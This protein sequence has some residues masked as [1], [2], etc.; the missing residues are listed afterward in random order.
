MDRRSEDRLDTGRSAVSSKRALLEVSKTIERDVIKAV[1]DAGADAAEDAAPVVIVLFQDASYFDKAAHRFARVAEHAEVIAGFAGQ[2]RWLPD[3]V[4][5]LPLDDLDEL[6]EDWTLLVL[7]AYA[8]VG[9][10]STDAHRTVSLAALEA[11][12]AFHS[13]VSCSPPLIARQALDVLDVAGSLLPVEVAARARARAEA[14]LQT[15]SSPSERTHQAIYEATLDRM[16]QLGQQLGL[17]EDLSRIDPLTGAY[18]RRFLEEQLASLGRRHPDVGVLAFDL[19][20]FKDINDRYGHAAGDTALRAFVELLRSRLRP[21]SMIVRLGG[22]E[23]V[24]LVPGIDLDGAHAR[25][26]EIVQA[27]QALRLPSP[28]EQ[29][30]MGVSVG[31]D[32]QQP[33]RLDL[34]AVDAALYRAKTATR[35]SVDLV[36]HAGNL[37]ATS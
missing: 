12:R 29:V 36:D 32:R 7:S 35:G 22:D 30:R 19:D 24:A 26:E 37:S 13:Q 8:S 17:A 28:F 34:A 16:L 6:A 25:A 31:V 4:I 14:L 11:N 15:H 5:H 2:P 23:F 10:I 9:L 27:V 18:N 21:P 3:G 33:A 20:A 1:L